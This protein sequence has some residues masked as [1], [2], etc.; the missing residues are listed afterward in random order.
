MVNED[1]FTRDDSSENSDGSDRSN[2]DQE[3]SLN[4]ISAPK[5][6][7][8]R[9]RITRILGQGAFGKVLLAHDVILDRSVA[10]K[11]LNL[12]KGLSDK[13]IIRKRELIINEAR[14]AAKLHHRN[15]V[16]IHDII[17]SED[18][19]Y[20]AMHYVEGES[21]KE[22]LAREGSQDITWAAQSVVKLLDGLS[23]AHENNII[24][25]DIKPANIMVDTSGELVL[26]DFGLAKF[27]DSISS[28]QS[29]ELKGTPAYMSPE[30]IRAEKIDSR[31]DIF[32]LTCVLYEMITGERPFKGDNI[33]SISY[34]IIHDIP[35][36]A[37]VSGSSI[38]VKWKGVL[39][40]GFQKKREERYQ[41]A[42][43]YKRA[44]ESLNSDEGSKDTSAHT[45]EYFDDTLTVDG[46]ETENSRSVKM[47]GP[48]STTV[49]AETS[50]KKVK[51]TLS[52]SRIILLVLLLLTLCWAGYHQYSQNRRDAISKMNAQFRIVIAPF[53]SILPEGEKE[54]IV[55]RQM[56]F[57]TLSKQL[58]DEPSIQILAIENQPAPQTRKEA[59]ALGNSVMADVLIWA[60]VISHKGETLIEPQ[61]VDFE[62]V[63]SAEQHRP[64]R[65][66]MSEVPDTI[67]IAESDELS[68]RLTKAEEIA[69][70]CAF[71]TATKTNIN[72][73]KKLT[74]LEQFDSVESYF[75]QG[76]LYFQL[77]EYRKA[78]E[79][80]DAAIEGNPD[81]TQA[82]IQRA[83]TTL[84]SQK[85]LNLDS[86][87]R[88]T[89]ALPYFKK[90]A[91]LTPEKSY[92][93]W[94]MY[95]CYVGL[96]DYEQ[97]YHVLKSWITDNTPDKYDSFD[98]MYSYVI[99]NTWFSPEANANYIQ[100]MKPRIEAGELHL[101]YAA[102]I[103][104]TGY[105][106]FSLMYSPDERLSILEKDVLISYFCYHNRKEEALSL[107]SREMSLTRHIKRLFIYYWYEL[108]HI[109]QM[110]FL[111]DDG[112]NYHSSFSNRYPERME[113]AVKEELLA[114]TC[115]MSGDYDEALRS[116]KN[117][118]VHPE[119]FSVFSALQT[120]NEANNSYRPKLVL[121]WGMEQHDSIIKLF[122]DAEDF[123]KSNPLE[124]LF[125][126]YSLEKNGLK[127]R[128]ALIK[129]IIIEK[130]EH[131]GEK[132]SP[133]SYKNLATSDLFLL[134]F[135]GK[136]TENEILT[137]TPKIDRN[138]KSTWYSALNF[139]CAVHFEALNNREKAHD[140]YQKVFDSGLKNHIEWHVARQ[141]L[142]DLDS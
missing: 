130:Q 113:G 64:F 40:K 62:E 118:T 48:V 117:L 26:T 125:Y 136:M 31:T 32:S 60:Q 56:L 122:E 13:E 51:G 34:S 4:E 7:G 132:C 50:D 28:T 115:L 30:Q 17:E 59:V 23:L 19:V 72:S 114:K 33:G 87:N 57:N 44:I 37:D 104:D 25:R 45:V 85:V 10:L 127:D 91:E 53:F 133:E 83:I 66:D 5:V 84:V 61:I 102:L 49:D 78:L 94:W 89:E 126:Y 108:K 3:N 39:S 134:F 76:L 65:R 27:S 12:G 42:A 24:H 123:T 109:L 92:G 95:Q 120:M 124:L 15:I 129:K 112:E 135:S 36:Y 54:G 97:A 1:D 29:G 20:I 138:L 58:D 79:K 55:F 82:Y 107:I 6:I 75:H 96:E 110:A 9:F 67:K 105:F 69:Q 52:K 22:K 100:K 140:Y 35:R 142:E 106:D 21:L 131:F 77:A 43:D 63:H 16:A 41:S 116:M 2:E 38:P 121:L 128:A 101:I 98:L 80:F 119:Y 74:F 99:F 111:I 8:K 70:W 103:M 86:K 68:F 14:A 18:A 73:Q 81:F 71:V 137:F 47:K 90:F 46:S 141:K 11:V 93:A 139:F 88:Y